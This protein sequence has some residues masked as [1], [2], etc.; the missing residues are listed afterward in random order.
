MSLSRANRRRVNDNSATDPP[1]HARTPTTS[2][3]TSRPF[4][5]HHDA[6]GRV[7]DL[8]DHRYRAGSLSP[9]TRSCS[10]ARRTS[11]STASR[12]WRSRT[13]AG[14]CTRS[15]KARVVGDDPLVRRVYEFDVSE[16]RYTGRA[17][18]TAWP[19]RH[20]SSPTRSP[21]A[22]TSSSSPSATTPGPAAAWKKAFV[23]DVPGHRPRLPNA[24]DRRPAR[25]RKG[26]A[27]PAPRR[28]GDFGLGR[29]VQ[30]PVLRLSRR[31]FRS[32]RDELAFVN[33]TNFGSTVGTLT[34]P[35]TAISSSSRSR[36][37][38]VPSRPGRLGRPPGT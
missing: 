29:P 9:T 36:I 26:R 13:T 27:R 35:I 24:Q 32:S 4:I 2:P 21:S 6:R 3:C 16:R 5:V 31:C 30:V 38:V 15:S 17:G 28:P 14:R 10:A 20:C 7:V 22:T 34:F 33:D 37:Q 18:R 11:R 12:R 25:S 19:R 8:T 1:H 23:I